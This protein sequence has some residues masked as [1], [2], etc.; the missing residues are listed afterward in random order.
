[1]SCSSVLTHY[2]CTTN[3]RSMFSDLSSIA[4]CTD[5]VSTW[6]MENALLLNPSTL[7]CRLTSMMT[8]M[9]TNLLECFDPLLHT[10]F[11]D[12]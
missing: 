8:C 4:D 3:T 7:A 9:T 1:M 11:N 2:I 5:A 6:F 12:L 10:C